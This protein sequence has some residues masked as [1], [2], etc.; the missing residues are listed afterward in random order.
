MQLL[1]QTVII[2][3]ENIAF[4]CEELHMQHTVVH[5]K[6]PLLFLWELWQIWND[7]INFTVTFRDEPHKKE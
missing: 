6:V 5:K 7:F 1:F 4:S 3:Q 2:S